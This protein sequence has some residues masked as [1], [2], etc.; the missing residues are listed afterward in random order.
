MTSEEIF[1]QLGF[2]AL[3]AEVYIALLKH[4]PQTAYKV[5]K[6]LNRPTANVYKA[7]DVLANA[8]AIEIEE[9]DIRVCKAMPI[10]TL[11]QQLQKGYKNK[12]DS[13]VELLSKLKPETS[14]EGIYKLQT[15]ESVLQRVNE[16]LKRCTNIAVIDSFPKPLEII[17]Q[18]LN[19]LA[20]KKIDVFVEAYE[21]IDLDE[22]ISISMPVVRAESLKYWNAQQLNV[23]IDGKEMLVAIFNSDLTEVIQATYSNSNYLACIMFI[24]LLN[25]HRVHKFMSAKTLKEFEEVK[26]G[27]KYFYNS[28]IPG[29]ESLFKLY[30]KE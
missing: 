18:D 26:N 12:I 27:Q 2:N 24:G 28:K 22:S 14:E 9:G 13:A 1:G 21:E 25:E 23:A 5:G 3:E 16:M 6:L 29:V 7:V 10:K 20:K 8:G 19:K 30:K 15:V 11:A 4:G 17:K